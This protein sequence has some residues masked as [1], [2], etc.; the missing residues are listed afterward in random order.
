MTVDLQLPQNPDSAHQPLELREFERIYNAFRAVSGELDVLRT[1]IGGGGGGG[2][3]NPNVY[4]Q[5]T[6]PSPVLQDSLWIKTVG[7][8]AGL[9]ID[10]LYIVTP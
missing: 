9:T 10:D 8:G 1:L 7:V 2:G 5:A 6:D 3:L 4:I